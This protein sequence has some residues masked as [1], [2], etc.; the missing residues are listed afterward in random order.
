M[1]LDPAIPGSGA[2]RHDGVP[3]RIEQGP[4]HRDAEAP[5][6]AADDDS[7][8]EAQPNGSHTAAVRG[9][10]YLERRC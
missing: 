2:S 8:H 5:R 6:P 3:A 9:H 4:G 1:R 7:G 10:I